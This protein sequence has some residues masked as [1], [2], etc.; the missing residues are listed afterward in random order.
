MA[1][2]IITAFAEAGDRSLMPDAPSGTNSNYQTGY[3]SEYEEDPVVNP[4]TAKFV[5]RDKSN[6][7][8]NDIT[9]NIKEWQEHTYPAFITSAVNG[10]VP[11]S[12]EKN[13]IVNLSGVD[14]VSIADSNEDVPPSSK[15]VIHSA[16][17]NDLSQ[18]Y[19]FKTVAAFKAFENEFP[20]GK[21]ANLFR[22]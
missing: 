5:E 11:F 9:A 18:T 15:W 19:N 3:P 1:K 8:F 12:Y 2:R 17:I 6:Q 4:S 13:S 10:G 22:R 21:R 7:L 14:Y 16:L 20:D